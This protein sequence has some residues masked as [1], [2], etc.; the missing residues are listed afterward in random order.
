MPRIYSVETDEELT[1][2]KAETQT[3]ALN[4]VIKGKY[5]VSTANA[6]DVVDY[7]SQGGKVEDACGDKT[8]PEETSNG[9]GEVEEAQG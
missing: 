1:L 4:H 2:V 8:P 9:E 5:K 6:M 3:Q 7:M